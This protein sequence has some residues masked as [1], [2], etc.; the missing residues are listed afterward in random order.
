M[1]LSILSTLQIV[2]TDLIEHNNKYEVIFHIQF[3]RIKLQ[4]TILS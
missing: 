1:Y 3:P 2:S 4:T